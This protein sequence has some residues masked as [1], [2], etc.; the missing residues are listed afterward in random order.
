MGGRNCV[1]MA[2]N[3]VKTK[4]LIY[5]FANKGDKAGTGAVPMLVTVWPQVLSK[6]SQTYNSIR[7]HL[8]CRAYIF[9]RADHCQKLWFCIVHSAYIILI[10]VGAFC[11]DKKCECVC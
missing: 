4:C 2:G 6:I 9:L 5:I 11:F 7:M 10:L 3:H 8:V 1:E